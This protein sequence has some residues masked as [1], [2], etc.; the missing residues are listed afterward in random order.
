[1][2]IGSRHVLFPRFCSQYSASHCRQR[3]RAQPAYE[4]STIRR[5]ARSPEKPLA[6]LAG[7]WTGSSNVATTG[8]TYPAR[9]PPGGKGLGPDNPGPRSVRSRRLSW[10][11]PG[12]LGVAP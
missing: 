12:L 3:R 9:P 7:P 1:M 8:L 2:L 6:R 5:I 4:P 10:E 11:P